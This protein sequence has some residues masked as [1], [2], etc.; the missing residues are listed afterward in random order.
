MSFTRTIS[1]VVD[2]KFR[3]THM[4]SHFE[5]TYLLSEN[6]TT[7]YSIIVGVME[8]TNEPK[9]AK[10]KKAVKQLTDYIHET[11]DGET[12]ELVGVSFK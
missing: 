2:K 12:L 3:L 11:H 9:S 4:Y 7:F 6:E 8:L 5:N 1:N 10:Q